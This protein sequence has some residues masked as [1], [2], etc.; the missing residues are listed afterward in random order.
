MSVNVGNCDL[1]IKLGLVWL[2]GQ[3]QLSWLKWI[4]NRLWR[5]LLLDRDDYHGVFRLCANLRFHFLIQLQS[6]LNDHLFAKFQRLK[7]RLWNRSGWLPTY[8]HRLDKSHT[9]RNFDNPRLELLLDANRS[10]VLGRLLLIVRHVGGADKHPRRSHPL[11]RLH[12]ETDHIKCSGEVWSYVRAELC[13]HQIP[14]VPWYL[15]LLSKLGYKNDDR[16]RPI[17]PRWPQGRCRLH[18]GLSW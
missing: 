16:A 11:H 18:Q 4:R 9:E 8:F 7:Q 10:I 15:V 14:V 6:R 5:L 3:V 1:V 13:R 17:L 2:V 12:R